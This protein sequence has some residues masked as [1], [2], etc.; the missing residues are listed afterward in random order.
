MKS[1]RTSSS[2]GSRIAGWVVPCP[3][4]FCTQSFLFL[5]YI[6]EIFYHSYTSDQKRHS[7]MP[8]SGSNHPADSSGQVY[9]Y[10]TV[11]LKLLPQIYTPH[12][13]T[14]YILPT[15]RQLLHCQLCQDNHFSHAQQMCQPAESTQATLHLLA[16]PLSM[17]LVCHIIYTGF[18]GS[19]PNKRRMEEE[20][21]ASRGLQRQLLLQAWK[22]SYSQ[23]APTLRRLQLAHVRKPRQRKH[24]HRTQA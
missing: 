12:Q 21:R 14:L 6:H 7:R 24:Q 15:S 8:S 3:R 22:S 11:Y 5:A 2:A 17:K 16:S 13:Y 19:S 23:T 18:K 10:S 4:N 1:D 20:T 9:H